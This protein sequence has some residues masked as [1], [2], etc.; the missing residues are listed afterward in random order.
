MARRKPDEL[1]HII[2]NI[3]TKR[4]IELARPI[5]ESAFFSPIDVAAHLL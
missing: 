1:P 5:R 4:P 2:L 3:Q